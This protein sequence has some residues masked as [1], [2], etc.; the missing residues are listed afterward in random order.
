MIHSIPKRRPLAAALTLVCLALAACHS[1]PVARSGPGFK[2][3]LVG[4]PADVV[5]PTHGLLVRRAAATMSTR[6]TPVWERPAAAATSSCC[7][8]R[9]TTTTTNTSSGSATATRSRRSYSRAGRPPLNPIVIETIRNAEA[10]FI[11]GGDQSNYVRLLEGHAGPG[12]DQLRRRQ[13]RTYRR[14][15]RGHGDHGRILLLGDGP[16]EA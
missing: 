5:R 2:Y 6:T 8:H 10:I 15:Q 7:A 16:R 3:Y 13:A 11:G 4:N 12:R 1:V 9:A 14:D